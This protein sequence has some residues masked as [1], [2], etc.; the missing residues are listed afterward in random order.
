MTIHCG[1][2]HED[3]QRDMGDHTTGVD[4]DI[5]MLDSIRHSTAL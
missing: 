5:D 2:K 1:M 4:I 3:Y